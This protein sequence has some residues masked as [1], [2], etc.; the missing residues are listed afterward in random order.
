[1]KTVLLNGAAADL[2][3]LPG[4]GFS[5][6]P[7][8][9]RTGSWWLGSV[10]SVRRAAISYRTN[11]EASQIINEGIYI[12]FSSG[13]QQTTTGF[14]RSAGD[15]SPDLTCRLLHGGTYMRETRVTVQD[16]AS[17]ISR[18]SAVKIL[19]TSL[20]ASTISRPR[21]DLMF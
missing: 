18:L 11:K 20:L 9:D 5:F 4:S 10:F 6:R 21:Q 16:R 14:R 15:L 2:K 8:R 13:R 19:R 3:T 12:T 1:M 7:S 17:L